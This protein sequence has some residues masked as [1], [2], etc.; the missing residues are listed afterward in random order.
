MLALHVTSA[1]FSAPEK[2]AATLSEKYILQRNADEPFATFSVDAFRP[3]HVGGCYK[4]SASATESTS[5]RTAFSFTDEEL[6]AAKG[7]VSIDWRKHGAVGPVQQQHPFGTCWAFSMVAVTE[8]VNVIQ[9]KKPFQKLSEQMVVSCVPEVAC[10][11]NSDV[12]WSWA[13]HHTGGKYQ[14]EEDY[15]YNRT[16][17]FYRETQL[18]PDGTPDGYPGIC[19]AG[20]PCPPCPGISR[21]DGTPPCKLDESKGF[22]TASVQGWGMVTPH[23]RRLSDVGSGS[24]LD[25]TRM[26]AALQK[27]GPAQSAPYARS[28][29]GARG[30]CLSLASHSSAIAAAS[31]AELPHRLR[32]AHL[33]VGSCRSLQSASM[34]RA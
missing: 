4:P 31:L 30:L 26:V 3:E 23:G 24:P 2:Y 22:S 33:D 6:L 20:H 9:G 19:K 18:A 11:D 7:K 17:N 27:Y 25:V 21:Q 28:R 12:L 14:K 15:P 16:C 32:V 8:A 5:E 10:V 1:A 34:P 29:T 13:L